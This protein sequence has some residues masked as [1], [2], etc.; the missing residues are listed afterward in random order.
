MQVDPK[1]EHQHSVYSE[2]PRFY[3]ISAFKQI[4]LLL[5][6]ILRLIHISTLKNCSRKK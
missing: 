2:L 6:R 5:E 3:I 4:N 1:R